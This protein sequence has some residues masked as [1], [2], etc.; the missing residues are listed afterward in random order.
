M[1]ITF[2][3]IYISVSFFS[4]TRIVTFLARSVFTGT[5]SLPSP[6]NIAA[7]ITRKISGYKI[8]MSWHFICLTYSCLASPKMGHFLWW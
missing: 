7:T 5:I 8:M 3:F 2:L 4:Q 1:F 6:V